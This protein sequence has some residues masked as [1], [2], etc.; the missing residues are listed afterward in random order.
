M[1]QIVANVAT[2]IGLGVTIAS[3]Y[4]G[5]RA[6]RSPRRALNVM[7]NTL[8]ES[9]AN[10][11]SVT[12][13]SCGSSDIAPER[14]VG[15]KPV[16][17]SLGVKAEK[18]ASCISFP[19]R[20]A[21]HQIVVDDEGRIILNP[22]LLKVGE[23]IVANLETDGAVTPNA[24]QIK[25][26]LKDTKIV[27]RAPGLTRRRYVL[28]VVGIVVGILVAT[29]AL[30]WNLGYIGEHFWIT[31]DPARQG[32]PVQVCGTGI[33]PYATVSASLDVYP[34]YEQFANGQADDKG[35][36]CMNGA[37]PESVSPGNYSVEINVSELVGSSKNRWLSLAI[38][39]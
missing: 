1:L 23:S 3:A 39:P 14:F 15:G 36:F 27:Q 34:A 5:F 19:E 12:F 26:A 24:V 37:I 16:V 32:A 20:G 4:L 10:R 31:P 8:K 28:V 22:C 38:V 33:K 13:Q 29:L 35:R 18:V 11:C 17:V 25:D 9:D 2:V 7:V 21:N 6:T 30:A